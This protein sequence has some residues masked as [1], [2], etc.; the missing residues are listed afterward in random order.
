MSNPRKDAGGARQ[1][2]RRPAP[3]SAESG[4]AAPEARP[5]GIA[6]TFDAAARQLSAATDAP[7]GMI[8]NPWVRQWTSGSGARTSDAASPPTQQAGLS[9][10]SSPRKQAAGPPS[11]AGPAPTPGT[12][13]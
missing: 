10:E 1:R 3:R 13:T 11:D 8:S 9:A 7:K 5:A 12:R 2:P 6:P 4:A